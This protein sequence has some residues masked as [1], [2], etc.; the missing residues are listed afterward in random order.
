MLKVLD[1]TKK[2]ETKTI[3]FEIDRQ[4]LAF[5]SKT[6]NKWVIESG[7]FEVL[8]G[9]ISPDIRLKGNLRGELKP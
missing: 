7:K 2:G 1:S 3:S 5:F 6:Q 8:I 9:S 4:Q